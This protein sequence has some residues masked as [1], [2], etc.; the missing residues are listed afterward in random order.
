M[1]N[2]P[3]NVRFTDEVYATRMDVIRTL[4]TNLI[5]PMWNEIIKYRNQMKH[6][7]S[8][9]DVTRLPYF[10][11]YTIKNSDKITL[12]PGLF[13]RFTSDFANILGGEVTKTIVKRDLTRASLKAIAKLNNIQTSDISIDKVINHK[14]FEETHLVLANYLKA[15]ESLKYNDVINEEFLANK[16]AI[17]RGEEELTSFYRVEDLNTSSS[18]FFVSREYEAAPAK[19]IEFLMEGL[20]NYINDVNEPLINKIAATVY[21]FGFAKPFEKFNNEMCMLVIK[22]ISCVR[23]Q[24][25]PLE[26]ILTSN[27][28]LKAISKEVQKTRDLTYMFVPVA[29]AVEKILTQSLDK[30]VQYN[31][32]DMSKEMYAGDDKEEFKNEFGFEPKEEILAPKVE[33]EPVKETPKVEHVKNVRPQVSPKPITKVIDE[34]VDEKALKRKMNDLLEKDPYLK[35]TQAHFYVHHCQ[36]GRFYTIQEFKK[37]EKVVYE[38]ARTS[39]DNL[40]KLGYYRKEQIKN[41]FVYTP[42]EK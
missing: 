27:F 23:D 24:F 42:I 2:S 32:S 21:I 22:Q 16:L 14:A 28:D 17:L 29:D 31:G 33:L 12:I 26:G 19:D 7:L 36:L 3:I 6:N 20:F 9:L 4:G 37:E 39:M 10:I 38:T 34:E 30:I 35:K 13:K 25:I 41:K 1:S 18:H 8:L 40:V 5:D 15:L 11:T